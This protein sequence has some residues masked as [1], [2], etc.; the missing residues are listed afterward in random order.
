MTSN[1]EIGAFP[2]FI[3]N[4]KIWSTSPSHSGRHLSM[5]R[6][7]L[8]NRQTHLR[9]AAL[10][11]GGSLAYSTLSHRKP[12]ANDSG[13]KPW[14]G[15]SQIITQQRAFADEAKI[16]DADSE[17]ISVL[18]TDL[19]DDD[20]PLFDADPDSGAW[21]SLSARL[22]DAQTALSA[23]KWSKVGE[24]I[25]DLI[26][27]NW[28]SDLPGYFAKLQRELEMASGSLAEEI[29]QE[30][31]DPL[32]NPEISRI[33]QVR[34]SRELCTE[35]KL[36]QQRRKAYTTRALAKYLGIPEQDVEPED[37]PTIAMCG[38]GGG[39]R[40]LVAGT[41]SYL[42]AQ[43]GGLYDC[44]T[45][46]AGVSGS[47]W[48]QALY[49]STLGKQNYATLLT[50]LKQRIGTHIAY[51]PSALSLLTAAPTNKFLLSGI[52][53][54][55]KGNPTADFGLVDAYGVLLAARLFVPRGELGVDDRN[56]KV[57]NQQEYLKDGAHPLPIYTAVRHEIPNIEEESSPEGT[58]QADPQATKEKARKES[59]FQ[60]FES[61]PYEFWS[62]ELEAGIP[63]WSVGRQFQNGIGS[64]RENGYSVPELRIP[65][66]LGIW[67]SAF[68]A[69]LSHYYKE[70]RPIVKGLFGFGGIDDLLEERNDELVKVHPIEP[71][72]IPNYVLG[73]EKKLPPTAA[74]SIF[75]SNQLELADA[76]MSNNLPIYPLLRP[77]RDADILIAF[78][79][80]ADI[81]N[82]NWLS[83]ADGYARQRGIKGWPLGAGWPKNGTTNATA[84]KELD[85]AEAVS[86]QQAAGKIADARESRRESAK[87]QSRGTQPGIDGQSP[88]QELELGYCNVW[89]GTTLER[90]TSSEPPPSK[91]L[92]DP[93][94]DWELMDPNA[95]IAVIY[96]PFLPNPEVEGVNPNTSDYMSTW[97]FIYTPKDIDK[98]VALA[99]AN[100]R[101]G[102]EQ[103][104]RTVRAVYTRKKQKRLERERRARM[105]KWGRH[106]K[107][108][109]DHFW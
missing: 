14:P 97:N 87:S 86:P 101:A 66:M 58:Q 106:L 20:V 91:L 68:C 103:V 70:I 8:L 78:D 24:T 17:V 7:L 51:P 89:V 31:Q 98:V 48:L 1:R 84:A 80:S 107:E 96:F 108:S 41:S 9:A 10:L 76:G 15:K 40:A 50:H 32:L 47:C 90:S 81:K 54:K 56:L 13:G 39:L 73:L 52:V 12:I 92:T 63:S 64:V 71:A 22:S 23:T 100:F 93:S 53:E 28:A 75:A 37:V 25:S 38:S 69:T 42:S 5:S 77:G 2:G 104:K 46:T 95:G 109:G 26:L 61:T 83:V 18:A 21:A 60:W 45:Y 102:E 65:F 85:A 79:A 3:F 94:H 105:R 67:G 6:Q 33:A 44:V 11:I 34:I 99:R 62:E 36:F 30:A 55:V 49:F 29:W 27:P 16:S 82:E 88:K 57:S 19:K 43:E 35:E 74:K 59:W 72:S 4:L